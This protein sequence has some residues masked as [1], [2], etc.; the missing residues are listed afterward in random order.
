MTRHGITL[1][2]ELALAWPLATLVLELA[3][4][5]A[6]VGGRLIGLRERPRAAL[7]WLAVDVAVLVL[8][9]RLLEW[10]G[11]GRLWP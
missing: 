9:W 2:V 4:R 1:M 8:V 5:K 7:A 6:V 10:V 3:K 11:R